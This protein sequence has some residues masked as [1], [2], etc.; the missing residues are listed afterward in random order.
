VGVE[1]AR[2]GQLVL[3]GGRQRQAVAVGENTPRVVAHNASPGRT[4]GQFRSYGG[5][6]PLRTVRKHSRYVPEAT[7]EPAAP[8]RTPHSAAGRRITCRPRVG[9]RTGRASGPVP[10]VRRS[11]LRL[12]RLRQRP[13]RRLALLAVPVGGLGRVHQRVPDPTLDDEPP[14]DGAVLGP[15]LGV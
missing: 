13:P 15:A 6:F 2:F 3:V 4:G 14:V 9:T 8:H 12:E 5:P 7:R 1:G 11:G 10:A